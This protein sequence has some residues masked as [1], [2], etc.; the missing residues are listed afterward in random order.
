[1]ESKILFS[2]PTKVFMVNLNQKLDLH[3]S[4]SRSAFTDSFKR[5]RFGSAALVNVGILGNYWPCAAL[6]SSLFCY[7]FKRTSDHNKILDFTNQLFL[8]LFSIPNSRF[9]GL[10]LEIKGRVNSADRSQKRV[11]SHGSLPLQSFDTQKVYLSYG[12]SESKTSYGVFGVRVFF[13]Y[14][15]F[16]HF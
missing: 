6:F 4:S 3:T 13:S 11:I 1:L 15:L 10:R 16:K 7:F 2:K 9:K 5:Y 12:F 8:F 14:K